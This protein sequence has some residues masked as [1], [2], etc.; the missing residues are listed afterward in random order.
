MKKFLTCAVICLAMG[1]TS[2]ADSPQAPIPA[3]PGDTD[4]LP[5]PLDLS[6]TTPLPL[7]P[8]GSAPADASI[9]TTPAIPPP[10]P[11]PAAPDASAPAKPAD[12]KAAPA[13]DNAAAPAETKK[14]AAVAPSLGVFADYFPA[15]Q[16]S[17]WIY[18][19]LKPAAGS[20]TKKT[21]T[22]ECTASEAGADGSLNATFQVTEDGNAT[23]EK[24]S[25]ASNQ[26]THVASGETALTGE[27]AY[28]YP[29]NGK[30]AKWTSGGKSYKATLGKAV[31]YKKTYPNCVVVTGKSTGSLVISYYAKGI[32]LVAIEVYGKG[33]KLDQTQS[34]ALVSGPGSDK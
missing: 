2:W 4:A 12:T 18:E 25:L 17:K 1:S 13:A 8:A 14:E 3:P 32:G 24:Y 7:P 20:K 5:P 22:V 26:V 15:A 23:T 21:R 31:V 33:L 28:Q 30:M 19:Y 16:G 27:Y 9:S 29:A 10:P 11:A 34:I 6:Q